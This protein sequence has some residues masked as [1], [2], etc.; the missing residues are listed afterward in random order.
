[1]ELVTIFVPRV[2]PGNT[3]RRIHPMWARHV[4]IVKLENLLPI[5]EQVTVI[6]VRLDSTPVRLAALSVS[7]VIH[8]IAAVIQIFVPPEIPHNIVKIARQVN[9]TIKSCKPRAQVD[10]LPAVF[11][12]RARANCAQL[13]E[14]K[15]G[16][17]LGFVRTVPLAKLLP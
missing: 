7:I 16:P 15:R 11:W 17:A 14:K 6:H 5:Q 2:R 12:K 9:T 1:M 3:D 8:F 10:V 13:G 4:Q